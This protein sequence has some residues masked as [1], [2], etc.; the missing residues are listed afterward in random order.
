L[1]HTVY[2]ENPAR[3]YRSED[4]MIALIE[5]ITTLRPGQKISATVRRRNRDYILENIRPR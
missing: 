1:L 3:K 5:A 4:G 2:G